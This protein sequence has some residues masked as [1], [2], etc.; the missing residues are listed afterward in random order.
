MRME[1]FSLPSWKSLAAVAGAGVLTLAL[2]APVSAQSAS[3][4]QNDAVTT[5][6]DTAIDINVLANDT[7]PDGD[8]LTV[9]AV[10]VP[11]K[12]AATINSNGTVKYTPQANF[13]GT[14]SFTY[15]VTDG[16]LVSSATVTVTVTSVNDAPVAAADTV[17]VTKSTPKTIDVRA[18][19]TDVDGDT[20]TLVS[21]STPAHGSAVIAAGKV[22]YT[23]IEGYVGADAFTYVI[24][25]GTTTATGSVT[26]TVKETATPVGTFDAK[27]VTACNIVPAQPGVSALCGIYLSGKLPAWAQ[28]QVGKNILQLSATTPKHADKVAEAC[29]AATDEGVLQLCTVY[30]TGGLPVFVQERIGKLILKIESSDSK[31]DGFKEHKHGDKDHKDYEGLKDSKK[32]KDSG[33]QSISDSK[34][35]KSYKSDDSKAGN[36]GHRGY[37]GGFGHRGHR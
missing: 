25:D 33:S 24:S 2:V 32:S 1:R 7:D 22:T 9:A 29:A 13:H 12:G 17:E 28:Y 36:K 26:I 14:D 21:T 35:S 20:L 23:P 15:A 27:V 8:T 10:G 5:A 18:N 31:W 6:E 3:T 30:S 34:D 16:A 19:D 11:S 4:P 37:W